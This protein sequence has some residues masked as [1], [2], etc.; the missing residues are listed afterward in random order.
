V[1]LSVP[2]LRPSS[3]NVPD[4]VEPAWVIIIVIAQP[5]ENLSHPVLIHVPLTSTNDADCAGAAGEGEHAESAKRARAMIPR[6]I[7]TQ[8]VF[9]STRHLRRGPDGHLCDASMDRQS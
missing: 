7:W 9:N 2:P 1:P 8:P 3:V 4:N 6:R 5:V